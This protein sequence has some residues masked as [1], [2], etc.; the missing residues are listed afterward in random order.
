MQTTFFWMPGPQI[1]PFP[2]SSGCLSSPNVVV[3]CQT[4]S[5]IKVKNNSE[6]AKMVRG[7]RREQLIRARIHLQYRSVFCQLQT[8][9]R[10]T[11]PLMNTTPPTP[12]PTTTTVTEKDN[13]TLFRQAMLNSWLK[14]L[15][16]KPTPQLARR[17]LRW[18][19]RLSPPTSSL[20]MTTKTT[21]QTKRTAWKL[22]PYNGSCTSWKHLVVEDIKVVEVDEVW[23]KQKKALSG[24]TTLGTRG[25]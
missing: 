4:S 2:I 20:L 23:E 17:N 11:A 9:L 8:L 6:W 21:I 12:P 10:F 13:S 22:R 15:S 7:W 25:V 3:F 18:S 19:P 5:N 1:T 16:K 24:S 14:K